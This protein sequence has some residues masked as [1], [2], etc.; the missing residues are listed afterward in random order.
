MSSAADS[1][2]C[3][4]EHPSSD[5]EAWAQCHPR[6]I[7]T[8]V[9]TTHHIFKAAGRVIG[10]APAPLCVNARLGAGPA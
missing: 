8:V 9:F 6:C 2:L 10:Q 5:R 1:G 7:S 3:P 4:P